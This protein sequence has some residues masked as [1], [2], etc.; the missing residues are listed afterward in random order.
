MS[1]QLRSL[2]WGLT[3][4][5]HNSS[6]SSGV[7]ALAF[8]LMFVMWSALNLSAQGEFD[9]TVQLD[10]PADVTV[11]CGTNSEDFMVLGYPTFSSDCEVTVSHTDAAVPGGNGC[12]YSI[13]RTWT[14]SVDG[15]SETC[16]HIITFEDT[17][18]PVFVDAPGDMTYQC[19]GDIP[20]IVELT[21]TD[22]NG[23]DIN[24]G[25][26]SHTGGDT[27]NCV[28]TTSV[29]PGPDW[30]IW[31]NG[32]AMQGLQAN[33]YYRWVPGT[34]TMTF[35][36]DGTAYL[37]GEVENMTNNAQKWQVEFWMENGANW[38]SWSAM[39]RSYKDDLGL[40]APYYTA[41]S[42]YE[43]V[44]VVS[45][46]TGLGANAGSA[47][48][49]SHQPSNYYFGFQFGQ[50][51]NNRNANHGGSGWFYYFGNVN[52][53]SVEGHGDLTT[54]KNC[55]PN[56][57]DN[58]CTDEFTRVWTAVDDCGN[59]TRHTQMINVD[60]NTAPVF[61]N[62]P[63]GITINCDE[64]PMGIDPTTLIA[65]DN[66]D[67][68]VTVTQIGEGVYETDG[69]CY[70]TMT[71]TYMAEDN[72][73]NRAFCVYTVTI[74]DIEPAVLTV[75]AD[76]TYSCEEEIVYEPA[77]ATD[78][79]QE[80]AVVEGEMQTIPGNCPQSYTII[81]SFSVT[82]GCNGVVTGTQTITVVDETAPV[83][84]PYPMQVSVECGELETVPVPTASDN[85]DMEVDVTV[86]LDTNS[87]GCPYV[88][89]RYLTATDDC[90]NSTTGEQYI[91]I[92]DNTAPTIVVPAD[93]TVECDNV[94]AAPGVEGAEVSDNC[95]YEVSVE[96]DTE[97]IPGECENSY[98][99]LWIWTATD[100]CENTSMDTTVVTVVD[101]TNPEI[102]V[103]GG[104]QFSC[105]E[106]IVYGYAWATDNCDD[107]VSIEEGEPVITPGI[108]PSNYTIVVTYT[109]YDN[110]GNMAS[111]SITYV[112][113]DDEAPMFGEQDNEFS[114][115]CDEI[116]PVI[117]PTATDNCSTFD[118]DYVDSD[119]E[120]ADCD[121]S[122]VRTWTA[123]DACGNMSTFN[124][125]ISI[126]DETAPV[127]T[128]TIEVSM[129]CD[130]I[131]YVIDVTA[132]DNCD[133]N[134][135]I[136]WIGD[137]PVSGTC[138][139]RLIRTYV[140]EDN[141]GN[142]SSFEQIITLIDDN[143]PYVVSQTPNATYECGQEFPMP[144]VEFGD[145]CSEVAM[146]SDVDSETIDCIEYITYTFTGTDNCGN[147]TTTEVVYTIIDTQDPYFSDDV[148]TS[149]TVECDEELPVIT[150]PSAYDVCDS[151]VEVEETTDMVPGSCPSEYTMYYMY[152][153]FDDCGNEA[154]LTIAVNV[155]DTTVPEFD[156]E[157]DFAFMYE[158]DE[159][160]PVIEPIATDNCSTPELTY[161]DNGEITN[162]CQ[163][164][165]MRTWTATDAC[166]NE[167]YF[168]QYIMV[169]DETA[170]VITGDFEIEMPCDD[171]SY[172]IG[173]TATD[174]CDEDVTISWT[175]DEPVSG[176][177]AGR[178]IRTYVATDN[179]GNSTSFEQFVTLVD[180]EA[181]V[182]SVD[183]EDMT[184]ECG[185]EWAPANV[186]FTDNCDEALELFPDLFVD[187]MECA[188][189]YTYTW[190]AIDHCGNSTAVTQTITVAD[191]QAPVAS[192]EPMDATYECDEEWTFTD[193]MFTDICDEEVSVEFG[194]VPS[195]DQCEMVYTYSWTATDDCGHT[196][197][198][199]Q[200]ITV[201]D[202]TAPT[203]YMPESNTAEI[204]CEQAFYTIY[205][206]LNAGVY[207]DEEIAAAEAQA[208]LLFG[209]LGL[210]PT[211]V[212]DN[213][214]EN[215]TWEEVDVIIST[216]VDCPNVAVIECVFRAID[217]CGNASDEASSFVYVVDETA[218]VLTNPTED[219]VIECGTEPSGWEPMFDD[220][221][222]DDITVLPASSITTDGCTTYI[223]Q[224]WTATDPCGNAI[225]VF[226]NITIV[227]TTEPMITGETEISMPCDN[228]SDEILVTATDNCDL[229]VVIEIESD[230]PA[231]GSC[232]GR[233]IRTYSATD[234][235]G[236]V[237]YFTQFI[238]LTDVT[239]PVA[240]IDPLDMTVECGSEWGVTVPM[241]TDNC[242]EELIIE[243]DYSE[244]TVDC[245]TTITYTWTATDHCGNTTTVDQV[246]TVVDTTAPTIFGDDEEI[247]IDCNAQVLY[248]Q[249]EAWD[250]CDEVLDFDSEYN[251][252]PGDC[253]GDY[254]EVLTFIVTD[255]C[256]NS[257][258]VTYTTHH[259]D[260]TAP[261]LV[262]LPEGGWVSC[263][264]EIMFEMP[265]ATDDCS[266]AVVDSEM[267]MIPGNCPNSYTVV[268]TFWAVDGCGNSSDFV[269]VVYNVY[270]D[271][272]PS[273]DQEFVDE[274]Y[275]CVDW[276]SYEPQFAS[277]TDNCGEVEIY[278]SIYPMNSDNC[279]NGVWVVT[280]EAVD[281]CYN[282]S[283]ASYYIYVQDETDPVLAG[284]P[285]DM[286][287]E[288]GAE[289]PEVP[290][291]TVTDNCD[292]APTLEYDE[293]CSGDCPVDGGNDCALTTPVRPANNPCF[294]PTDWAMALFSLPNAYK[295]YIIQPGSEPSFVQNGDGTIDLSVNL[296][297]YNNQTSGFAV[298]VSFG[299]EMTWAQW[300]SQMF[301]TGFKA[302][303]GGEAANH[304]DWLYYIMVAGEGAELVGFGDYAG[305]SLNIVHAPS[306]N[307]FGFQLGD[308][309]NNYN[310]ANG[311]GGWFQ[312]SGT[313]LVNGQPI[314]S[315]SSVSGAGDF[316]FEVD[317]C[318]DYTIT[319][320]WT[321]WDCSGN[322]VEYCQT[323]TYGDL[324]NT[325]DTVVT[326]APVAVDRGN[327]A[328]TSVQPNPAT[329]RSLIYFTSELDGKLSLQ[330]LDMTGRVIA[331]LYNNEASAGIVY[332]ADFNVAAI[333]SGTY[334]I[335]LSNGAEQK[336]ERIQVVK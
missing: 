189:V 34:A 293:Y 147:S 201:V 113:Y 124:Q 75:P 38:A 244:E 285:A 181:P 90:G 16:S 148:I 136:T 241:F 130:D 322:M 206:N 140:A 319:R 270:D 277:A 95:E 17:E 5:W 303:C 131:S 280:Y 116:I 78:N 242:D 85:C 229:D 192:V 301:P 104:G 177:C 12:S 59:V 159:I 223:H 83:F 18:G 184:V 24:D 11:E 302:D 278:P 272:A 269:D 120:L 290:M 67:D 137:E 61:V 106:E 62:C 139:G 126:Y 56:N 228:I 167:N 255:D 202:T 43:L 46:M 312:Y 63:D 208:S 97:V 284:L 207:T 258:S 4:C 289:L 118:L 142:T 300:S 186:T 265:T 25:F 84:N 188:T 153:A 275:E 122:F 321:A 252:I 9:C 42:Y 151:E 281:D 288:C 129:P 133:D 82:D 19:Q 77:T 149:Y 172:E 199:D 64:T 251:V 80:V 187:E 183:P 329:E 328:I 219:E 333:E 180:E 89:I 215:A 310:G 259:E 92:I 222:N 165:F 195:G 273:F 109:A 227:D 88:I 76:A 264:D 191:T 54:D 282:S 28:L 220:E 30:S 41:W 26:E 297:S 210:L 60:D 249:P 239:A 40:G 65:T 179:C 68:A 15:N 254:T 234:D 263:E 121:D 294:Y 253:P 112:V 13:I 323:I 247:T 324:D 23:Y 105:D 248:A 314:L 14:V 211:G 221:C 169:Y 308:G 330:V 143:D 73:L 66:C 175:G 111:A 164:G 7:K 218:P 57:P 226:H 304:Q 79:C 256:G 235:C 236:N 156:E 200:V 182:A 198:V 214:D 32:M 271:E 6:L 307:Y 51:A 185:S 334:M 224:S 291:V 101:T 135:T 1:K 260:N 134:V 233:L 168:V 52:G 305:S 163:G 257:S 81:R 178:F 93:M 298:N 238:N 127:I 152:R 292:Q 21:A 283:Y 212:E 150:M 69:P 44:P 48:Y 209:E 286:V 246:I 274:T 49:M 87:G 37:E 279:G 287:M 70:A 27:S 261:E 35:Y 174:N 299:N 8:S 276:A 33:D 114:Y 123:T 336:I 160:I 190:L 316:A 45:Q 31:L 295:Y 155:V 171:I 20:A 144:M 115:E 237:A 262:G 108:C 10:C 94:P 119:T 317:C 162:D 71:Y 36:D 311:F 232:A 161:E 266:G 86:E 267:E 176:G 296:V 213:C 132:T 74:V 325:F 2:R 47:L 194:M 327:I 243:D 128:G 240:S 173:V 117:E 145:A 154:F 125:Y 313:F 217:A 58:Q 138:A 268:Y 146:E 326:T 335:R 103:Q 170:P 250:A 72:C 196:T 230:E 216:D 306:N 99:I 166:G 50:G 197:V 96:F 331:N 231:S 320:C 100:Y 205:A 102:F 22:C 158:C 53:E 193:V 39:G 3:R 315:G 309:A 225:T 318:P 332:S 55:T 107:E 203:L 29:G 141:C 204:P 110:C 91:T 157:Q 98:T 245:V